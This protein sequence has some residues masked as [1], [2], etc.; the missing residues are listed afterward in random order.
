MWWSSKRGLKMSKT[1]A[2]HKM[3][4]RALLRRACKLK[5]ADLVGCSFSRSLVDGISCSSI[6]N[7]SEMSLIPMSPGG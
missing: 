3:L 7:V 4:R 5:R 1:T 2:L 6:C